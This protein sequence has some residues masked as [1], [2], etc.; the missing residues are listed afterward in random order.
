VE[1]S[2]SNFVEK[3]EQKKRNFISIQEKVLNTN[4]V[5]ERS[6]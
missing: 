4:K 5:L 6:F 2:S 1:V 3:Q